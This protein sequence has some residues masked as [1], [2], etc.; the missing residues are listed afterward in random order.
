MC[1]IGYAVLAGDIARSLRRCAGDLRFALSVRRLPLGVAAFFV[2][3]WW[4]AQRNEDHFSL[5]SAIR[6][7]ELSE[8]L[9]LARGR[10]SIVELGTGT[11][12]S[13]IALALAERG[14]RVISYDPH[15]RPER[16]AYVARAWP[17]VRAHIEF[18]EEPD[19]SGPRPG[20]TVDF[21]FIDSSH[22]RAS[23]LCAFATW[24]EAL[25]P[26]ALVAFHDYGHPSYPGVRE[27]VEELGLKGVISGSLFVW[28]RR[29]L[30]DSPR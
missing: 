18:R 20:E 1:S 2:R 17:S 27:A 6:P 24:R 26:D 4:C 19:S 11:G 13:T 25:V 10:T 28:R 5:A 22:D 3:A 12:W 29:P 7:S 30:T 8:L 15:V 9:R 14:R 21:L 23:V 16:D